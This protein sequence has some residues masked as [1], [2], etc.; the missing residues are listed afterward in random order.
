M[1]LT[2]LH[3]F[4]YTRFVFKLCVLA[5]K[6]STDSLCGG[7]VWRCCKEKDGPK[8]LEGGFKASD[9]LSKGR[10]LEKTKYHFV[11]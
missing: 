7:V 2:L 3:F 11:G 6:F 8:V 4:F 5:D 1:A 9:V 10:N